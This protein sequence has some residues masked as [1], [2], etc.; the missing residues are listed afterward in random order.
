V[1]TSNMDYLVPLTNSL[2]GSTLVR[3]DVLQNFFLLSQDNLNGSPEWIGIGYAVFPNATNG[4]YPLYRFYMTTNVA[5]APS[6]GALPPNPVTL[7]NTF[8]ANV[9]VTNGYTNAN[10][11]HILDGVVD[12]R[13]RAYNNN[14]FWLTNYY[15]P[16]PLNTL[17]TLIITNCAAFTPP[18]LGEYG[19]YLFSNALPATV[20]VQMGVLEDRVVRHAWTLPNTA[21]GYAQSA[22]LAQEAGALHIFRQRVAV[23]NV[24]LSA[25][26]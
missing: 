23:P 26:P 12:L 6:A 24:D 18:F 15:T 4:L 21:P 22:Y 17:S 7:F 3:T 8:M 5:R 1:V 16:G 25:Y 11:S 10:W 13:V 14:G 20:E 19:I 2:P 9:A